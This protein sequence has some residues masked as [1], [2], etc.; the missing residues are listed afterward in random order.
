[1]LNEAENSSFEQKN[2]PKFVLGKCSA[3]LH[4]YACICI[5]LQL[6][7]PDNQCYS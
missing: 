3:K 7:K 6:K 1:M 5:C 2:R 4:L